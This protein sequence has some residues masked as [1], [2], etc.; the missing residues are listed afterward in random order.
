MAYPEFAVVIP[1]RP[2]RTSDGEIDTS[3]FRYRSIML[4]SQYV[5]M[6]FG[7]DRLVVS[8]TGQ[9]PDQPFSRSKAINLGIEVAMLHQP[10]KIVILDADTLV[11][12]ESVYSALALDAPWVFPYHWYYNLTKEATEVMYHNWQQDTKAFALTEPC[13]GEFE[14]KIESW[15]GCL[16]LD[17]DAYI[18][19]GGFDESFV[20]W[21][22]EDTAF[23]V[24][25]EHRYGEALRCGSFVSHL[26]HPRTTEVF[27]SPGELANRKRFFRNYRNYGKKR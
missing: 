10:D 22:W 21:G 7:E 13:E 2:A 19:T 20:D 18:E 15:S 27:G 6:H 9:P 26:W 11:P 17:V 4:V 8:G 3:S 12:V 14:H 16:V 24:V 5:R 23:R 1:Y 25:M